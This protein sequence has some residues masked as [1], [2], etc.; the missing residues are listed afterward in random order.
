M[1]DLFVEDFGE[2]SAPPLLYLHGGPGTGSYDFVLYQQDYLIENVRL[3]TFDQRGVLRSPAITD[4]DSFGINRLI[5][6]IEQI[7][8]S[9][10]ISKW[11]VLGHS[12]GGYLGV[13]YANAYPSSVDKLIF[14]NGTFDLASSA[15]SLLQGAATEYAILGNLDMSLACMNLIFATSKRSISELW[16]EF[17]DLTN[18][19][20]DHRNRLY[21]HSIKANFFE[22]IVK[23]SSLSDEDWGKAGMHQKRLFEEGAIFQSLLT[24]IPNHP[25]LLLKGK[26]DY[27]MSLDQIHAYLHK[28]S[29]T[30]LI[31]FENSGHF[32]HAEEAEK[33]STEIY[34]F[35]GVGK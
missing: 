15:R 18:G 19:L 28:N 29:H 2:K 22:D 1:T 23:R 14:E 9:L 13:L 21:V 11:T 33:F 30:E 7:R 31:I 4:A 12:F 8:K 5:E 17:T 20:G 10:S 25:T 24:H 27:V 35:I 34:R 26:F 32:P 16:S 3:I 6:D